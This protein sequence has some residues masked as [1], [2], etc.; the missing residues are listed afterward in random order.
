MFAL[1]LQ[2]L[3]SSSSKTTTV[4]CSIKLRKKLTKAHKRDS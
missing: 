3:T 4:S 2:N 1:L